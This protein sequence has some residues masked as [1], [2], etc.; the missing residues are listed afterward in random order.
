MPTSAAR[1]G[2]ERGAQ[3]VVGVVGRHADVDDRD[4][5]LVRADLAQQVLGV[6]GLR[7]DLEA[8]VLEQARGALAQQDG[9]VGDH[10]S[11]GISAHRTVPPPGGLTT[12]SSPS[13][14]ATRSARPRSPEPAPCRRRRGRRREPRRA[15]AR[16]RAT[17]STS[18]C[19]APE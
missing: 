11:H 14:A 9:V 15:G 2:S 10:D 3:A 19:V 1:R 13:S 6:A 4:V 17:T 12:F 8:G 16:P 7:H 5:G 18:T